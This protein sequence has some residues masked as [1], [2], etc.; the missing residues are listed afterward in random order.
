M[1]EGL[2]SNHSTLNYDEL[3]TVL[4]KLEDIINVSVVEPDLGQALVNVIS[5]ILGSHSD[6]LPFT[7]T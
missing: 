4:D 3:A 6:L 1:I 5:D 2:L 7:N